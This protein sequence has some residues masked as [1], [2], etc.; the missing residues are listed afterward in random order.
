MRVFL[1]RTIQPFCAE[2]AQPEIVEV[3]RGMLSRQDE[4]RGEPARG[5]RVRYRRKFDCFRRRADDQPDVGDT[6][7]SP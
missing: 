2:S 4:R 3:Q 5:Q 1:A 6:Q 7:P